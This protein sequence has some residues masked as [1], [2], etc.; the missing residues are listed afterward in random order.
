M[1][2][3]ARRREAA[4]RS[5]PPESWF[6][7]LLG[8]AALLRVVYLFDYSANSVFWSEMMLDAEVYDLWAR[9]IVAGDWI[10]GS[11]VFILP[12]LYPYFLA[13][14]YTIFG[15]KYSAVYAVQTVLGL[16]NIVMIHAIGRRVFGGY[17]PL[18]ASGV[19]VLYGSFMFLD[20][21]LMSTTLGLSLSLALMILLLVAGERQT[22]TLWGAAGAVLGLTALV[23]AETL[24]F[25]PFAAWWIWRVTR[26]PERRKAST[27]DQYALA[28]RQPL[29][30]IGVF[31]AFMMIAVSPA[32]LRNWIVTSDWSLSNLISSQ[33]GI[34]FYQANN[35]D[36]RGLYVPLAGFTG[37]PQEQS[38]EE[39]T[40]AEKETGRPMERS[41]VTRF[42]FRKGLGWILS[43]PVDFLVL[44]ANKLQRFL[45][46]YEY[47]T[48]YLFTVE[49]ESVGTLWAVSL[50]F[51]LISSLAM[52]GM[53][54]QAREGWRNP[55][56]LLMLFVVS[57]FIVV[58]L[59][60]V[61][62][63]YRMPSA[64]YL[65]LFAA[66]GGWRLWE[67]F[68][69]Q[70][71]ARRVEAGIYAAVAALLFVVFH[72]QVDESARIQEANVHYNAGNQYYEIGRFEEA[73][74]EYRRAVAGDGRNW[75]AF[76]NMGNTLQR[77][78]RTAEALEAYRSVLEVNPGMNA[79]RR[80]IRELE[81][82]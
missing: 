35:K 26:R 19:A 37:N 49:R 80:K 38:S 27:I 1:G 69:S 67:G 12:P 34:T 62:S 50:P 64:P 24:L 6:R 8:A 79:A 14:L 70:V 56:L 22:L 23:R 17:I 54:T 15:F 73:V 21:K 28:G 63:R 48:E 47:S 55:A 81:G 60:Y 51:A 41:E 75:R 16:L 10:G 78:G 71:A 43:N 7:G 58:M 9:D 61:S 74:G 30:A 20:A 72:L 68:R 39:K 42:W 59:F 5:E 66:A 29:F 31:A 82:R 36:A 77:L 33:A 46:S 53:A 3:A 57:N 32:T 44:E 2:R 65:I 4:H 11:D 76:F 13:L 18:I 25:F 45:G 52:I 40:L